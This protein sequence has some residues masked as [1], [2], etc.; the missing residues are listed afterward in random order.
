MI[1]LSRKYP[2]KVSYLLLYYS[3][4]KKNSVHDDIH[5][6]GASGSVIENGNDYGIEREID[7]KIGLCSNV[8]VEDEGNG[9]IV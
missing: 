8:N 4:E 7:K 2:N 1:F 5:V 9:N 3:N 6:G